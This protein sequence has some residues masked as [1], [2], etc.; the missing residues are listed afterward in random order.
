MS[1]TRM[2]LS[3]DA[4]NRRWPATSTAHT[5]SSWPCTHARRRAPAGSAAGGTGARAPR[6]GAA[7]AGC[8]WGGPPRTCTAWPRW[9][10]SPGAAPRSRSAPPTPARAP[11][12][13]AA[14]PHRRAP[15][16][17]GRAA[18][19]WAR[20]ECVAQR[21][22]GRELQVPQPH[23]GHRARA[24]ALRQPALYA[25]AVVGVAGGDHDR[26]RHQLLRGCGGVRRAA[27]PGRRARVGGAGVPR[28]R[29][30]DG[31]VEARRRGFVARARRARLARVGPRSHGPARPGRRRL[32]RRGWIGTTRVPLPGQRP[33]KHPARALPGRTRQ[34]VARARAPARPAAR[35]GSQRTEHRP[36]SPPSSSQLR[37]RPLPAG[38]ASRCCSC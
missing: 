20:L 22:V 10:G 35:P 12:P 2:V 27:A 30:T 25:H 33:P 16:A 14:A 4:E 37:D 5:I 28:A 36:P 13:R 19:P 7:P 21:K 11:A 26:V 38:L 31:A 24:V 15:A 6:A 32:R 9:A 29:H 23:A 8:W 34:A 17:R 3:A 18:A 1:H